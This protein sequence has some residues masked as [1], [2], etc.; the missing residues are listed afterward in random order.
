MAV[1]KLPHEAMLEVRE[2][3]FSPPK[4]RPYIRL[5]NELVKRTSTSQQ[6]KLSQLVHEETL[7]DSTLSQFPRRLQQ[8]AGESH[9]DGLI[10]HIFPERLPTEYR[11]VLVAVSP[12]VPV[13]KLANLADNIADLTS[14]STASTSNVRTSELVDS[15][16]KVRG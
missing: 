6:K 5:R 9:E 15:M 4:E 2:I 7:E 12:E 16:D 10:H 13:E 8:L 11:N 1:S 14:H 3:I